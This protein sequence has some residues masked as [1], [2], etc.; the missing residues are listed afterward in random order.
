MAKTEN[1][2]LKFLKSIGR[3]FYKPYKPGLGQIDETTYRET[4]ASNLSRDKEKAK[5]A[6]ERAWATRNFEIELYWKRATYFWAFLIPVF[7][8]V[9]TLFNSENY[10][11]PDPLTHHIEVY[12][13][14]CIG[15][16]LS[17][18]WGFVNK[19][20]KSWQRHWEIHV[21]LLEDQF[22]G[23]LYKTVN[24]TATFSVSKINEIISWFF[25]FIWVLLGFK[26]FIDQELSLFQWSQ[27]I[28]WLVLLTSVAV[29]LVLLSMTLGYGRG[30]FSHREFTMH[31]R[32]I[33]FINPEEPQ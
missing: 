5:A 21:D 22:T 26:Y 8:A 6:F 29:C 7:A 16:I 20:S 10:R 28:E 27:P 24:P 4:L 9:F 18:A 17:C 14:I 33:T 25:A 19:G 23:P 30:Y 32:H 13:I 2:T 11:T 31:R 1:K 3:I 15:F 12:I